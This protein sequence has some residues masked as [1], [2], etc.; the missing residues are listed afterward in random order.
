MGKGR[1][2]E[3]PQEKVRLD[4]EAIGEV[5]LGKDQPP[6]PRNEGEAGLEWEQQR[7]QLWGWGCGL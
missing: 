6:P 3:D 2:G 1:L 4:G 5:S 7:T